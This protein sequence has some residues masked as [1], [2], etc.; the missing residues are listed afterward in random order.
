MWENGI[1]IMQASE[2]SSAKGEKWKDLYN[3]CGQRAKGQPA[4]FDPEAGGHKNRWTTEA[5][6]MCDEPCLLRHSCVVNCD[7]EDGTLR[8]IGGHL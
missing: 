7:V 3:A 4:T 2:S 1:T 6:L 8:T 5:F